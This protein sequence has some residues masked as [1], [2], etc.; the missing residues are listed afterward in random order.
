LLEAAWAKAP[1]GREVAT[2]NEMLRTVTG[3]AVRALDARRGSSGCV[4]VSDVPVVF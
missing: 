2:R 3:L 4:S 1:P